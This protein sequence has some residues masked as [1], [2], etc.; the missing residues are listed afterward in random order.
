MLSRSRRKRAPISVQQTATQDLDEQQRGL[1]REVDLDEQEERLECAEHA[2]RPPLRKVFQLTKKRIARDNLSM[3]AAGVA[4]YVFLG[5]IPALGALISIYGLVS[6]P[7]MIQKQFSSLAGMLPSE[8]ITI[9]DE[10]MTRIALQATGATIGAL[11]GT[12]LALW[13]GAKAM[14]SVITGLNIAYHESETR[15][16]VRLNGTA[17]ALTFIGVM[18]IILAVAI[19][20]AVPPLLS[21]LRISGIAGG[22]VSFIRWPI[23]GLL[24]LCGF[25]LVYRYGPDRDRSSAPWIS[26]GALLGVALWLILSLGFSFYAS[27][28][29]NYNKTYGSLGAVV[30]LLLWF[31][32]SAYVLLIGAEVNSIVENCA[33]KRGDRMAERVQKLSASRQAH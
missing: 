16:L 30:V 27:H 15:G 11:V 10:Q 25:A 12:F 28:F 19:I 33:T 4:F 2:R 29:A 17:L 18:G 26:S 23:L 13:S 32:L 5:L 20:V 21:F 6:N 8:V 14:K 9:L 31:L 1:R 7:E 3:I 22:L 24:A